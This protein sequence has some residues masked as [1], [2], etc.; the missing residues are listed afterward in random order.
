MR[1]SLL[2]K[3]RLIDFIQGWSRHSFYKL[4]ISAILFIQ[5]VKI[6]SIIK[7]KRRTRNRT[8]TEIHFSKNSLNSNKQDKFPGRRNSIV[9]F[10]FGITRSLLTS[11]ELA[12]NQLIASKWSLLL[13]LHEELRH[14]TYTRTMGRIVTGTVGSFSR[15][16]IRGLNLSPRQGFNGL[17]PLTLCGPLPGHRS[18]ARTVN[19]SQSRCTVKQGY[20]SPRGWKAWW[21]W[22]KRRF[23][24]F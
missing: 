17:Q 11:Q 18:V 9:K 21:W 2:E 8:I 14:R 5:V 13:L 4:V 22:S 12:R 20:Q 16:E 6:C 15:N 1:F 24:S 23:V 10:N 19:K 3:I 7:N